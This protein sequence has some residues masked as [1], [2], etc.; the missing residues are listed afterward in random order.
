MGLMAAGGVLGTK[1]IGTEQGTS[2]SGGN[3][4]KESKKRDR[5]SRRILG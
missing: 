3:K 5:M 1:C 2:C 4:S